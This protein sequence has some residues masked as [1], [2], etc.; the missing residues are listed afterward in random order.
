MA[1]SPPPQCSQDPI[2]SSISDMDRKRPIAS[3]R[4]T[5]LLAIPLPDPPPG[6][7]FVSLHRSARTPVRTPA[8]SNPAAGSS[9]TCR[10]ASPRLPRDAVALTPTLSSSP[11]PR[12]K[13]HHATPH[14]PPRRPSAVEAGADSSLEATGT[15][16]PCRRPARHAPHSPCCKLH[17]RRVV[18]VS[19]L[20]LS[21][22][23]FLLMLPA[24]WL[25]R[26][27]PLPSLP[28]VTVA[29]RESIP[30]ARFKAFEVGLG[31][32]LSLFMRRPWFAARASPESLLTPGLPLSHLKRHVS[33]DFFV[34]RVGNGAN[35]RPAAHPLSLVRSWLRWNRG[36]AGSESIPDNAGANA[37]ASLSGDGDSDVITDPQSGGDGDGI[38]VAIPSS[39]RAFPH[40]ELPPWH[41]PVA[42]LKL[43]DERHSRRSSVHGRKQRSGLGKM[44]AVVYSAACKA[45]VPAALAA[46]QQTA[47]HG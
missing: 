3:R 7:S 19:L 37:P 11:Q 16:A 13:P 40:Q 25:A 36:E 29:P 23:L 18:V 28:S 46:Q 45:S 33:A 39:P 30:S 32:P 15:A 8:E 24:L 4:G 26:A 44:H 42:L 34:P 31:G 43:L 2:D 27:W 14:P 41:F 35:S 47:A 5:K 6:T 22:A 38:C 21:L 1:D 20:L 17:W 12:A 9:S 10:R